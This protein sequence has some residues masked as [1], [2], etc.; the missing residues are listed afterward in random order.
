MKQQSV[1]AKEIRKGGG[2]VQWLAR[3]K[4]KKK[5]GGEK[6]T[7]EMTQAGRFYAETG[8][9]LEIEKKFNH[10]ASRGEK[11]ALRD[12]SPWLD[13]DRRWAGLLEIPGIDLK[14]TP[15]RMNRM[16]EEHAMINLL[17]NEDVLDCV[18]ECFRLDI[19]G[20]VKYIPDFFRANRDGSYSVDEVKGFMR[21]DA[22]IKI[23]IAAG[24]YP[25]FVF[26]LWT[27]KTG[28]GWESR[29]IKKVGAA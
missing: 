13:I 8:G 22:M 4:L 25:Q 14:P 3:E 23:K 6:K 17:L 27:K 29:I 19:G 7:S 11:T 9:G 1:S 16:E 5:I 21:D 18:F 24:L 15:G 12:G 20:G 10:G 26:R 28:L 2:L